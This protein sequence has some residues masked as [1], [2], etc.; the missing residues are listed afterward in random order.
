MRVN[1][2]KDMLKA[3]PAWTWNERSSTGACPESRPPA[4]SETTAK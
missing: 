3:A 4:A 1:A 2:A